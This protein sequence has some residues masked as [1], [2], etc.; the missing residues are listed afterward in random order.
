[1]T[2]QKKQLPQ[3]LVELT[4]A[5]IRIFVDYAAVGVGGDIENR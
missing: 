1:M 3:E 2:K 4:S 5:G